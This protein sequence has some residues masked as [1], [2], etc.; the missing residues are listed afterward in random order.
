MPS[1]RV[2]L[3]IGTVRV[4][5]GSIVPRAAEAASA[6][7]TVE[8]S[9]ITISRGQPRVVIRFSED[10][11]DVA[12]QIGEHVAN[13]VGGLADVLAFQVTERVGSAWRR[14]AR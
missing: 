6:L 14:I 3:T 5:P 11:E 4:D 9:D 8:A 1:F 12:L 7:A 2:T 13:V 10:D